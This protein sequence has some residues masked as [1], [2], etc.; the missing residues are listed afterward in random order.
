M[1]PREI[2]SA[3]GLALQTE[4]RERVHGLGTTFTSAL[5]DVHT[6]LKEQSELLGRLWMKQEELNQMVDRVIHPPVNGTGPHKV[7]GT[8]K[9]PSKEGPVSNKGDKP[10]LPPPPVV[11]AGERLE[12]SDTGNYRITPE[13]VQNVQAEVEKI[14]RDRRESDIRAEERAQVAREA[15]ARTA[16]AEKKVRFV[17]FLASAGAGAVVG[18]IEAISWML[19]H[20][21]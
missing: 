15:N 11:V 7:P 17:V 4:F 1:S 18:I 14:K 8:V 2:T 12:G 19:H 21:H 6:A 3:E 13:M 20:V 16:T 5:Q 10:S 9:A